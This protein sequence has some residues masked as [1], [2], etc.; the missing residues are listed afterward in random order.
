MANS[1]WDAV[2][3]PSKIWE[4][5]LDLHGYEAPTTVVVQLPANAP[6]LE[7][8][9]NGN[10]ASRRLYHEYL[11][12]TA[13]SNNSIMSCN[14]TL[15]PTTALRRG[16][17]IACRVRMIDGDGD[18]VKGVV[19]Q[20]RVVP[21]RGTASQLH[22][23][24]DKLVAVFAYTPPSDGDTDSVRVV[25][26][27]TGETVVNGV[28]DFDIVDTP[29][30]ESIVSCSTGTGAS[31]SVPI[32][33]VINCTIAPRAGPGQ[34]IKAVASDFRI[35][36]SLDGGYAVNVSAV[37]PHARGRLLNFSVPLPSHLPGDPAND[38]HVLKLRVR[39]RSQPYFTYVIGG[40]LDL[41]VVH[42][43]YADA[44]TLTCSRVE[45]AVPSGSSNLVA[46]AGRRVV[47]AAHVARYE[48]LRCVVTPQSSYSSVTGAFFASKALASYFSIRADTGATST[49]VVADGG[50]QIVF[51]Y[52]CDCARARSCY[53][54]LLP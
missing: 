47:P 49:P 31:T 20:F 10:A 18:P 23:T 1:T 29:S 32:G 17:S 16:N 15:E 7:P 41:H 12:L 43:P 11:P 22:Q 39:A 38:H 28:A 3:A 9:H 45:R 4:L 6:G 54:A 26:H 36:A 34:S 21:N 48:T 14:S 50:L 24:R 13:A 42:R 37:V 27:A 40:E 2:P 44:S 8:L 53:H 35:T 52:G 33:Q 30:S 25:L 19:R 51:W 5:T 46:A